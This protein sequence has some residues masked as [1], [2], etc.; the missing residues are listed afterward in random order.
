[1]NMQLKQQTSTWR[2]W[3]SSWKHLMSQISTSFEFLKA[4]VQSATSTSPTKTRHKHLDSPT[5]CWSL[6]LQPA[7][8]PLHPSAGAATCSTSSVATTSPSSATSRNPRPYSP[9]W[10]NWRV[11]N[12]ERWPLNLRSRA[13]RGFR[14]PAELEERCF[15]WGRR[16]EGMHSH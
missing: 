8:S 12:W 4:L 1:M 14:I 15:A 3:W 10:R 2:A 16:A 9:I 13:S 7:N 6:Y 11:W 5:S